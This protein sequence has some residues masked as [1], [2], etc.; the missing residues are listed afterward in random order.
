MTVSR[1]SFLAGAAV[2][3]VS[4]CGGRAGARSGAPS[5]TGPSGF[6]VTIPGR[7][8][9]AEIPGPPQRVVAVGRSRDGETSVAL[10]VIPVGMSRDTTGIAPGGVAPWVQPALAGR[11]TPTLLDTT[12]VPPLEAIASLAP[13]LVLATDYGPLAEQY[14]VLS[15]VAP[16]VSYTSSPRSDTWQDATTRIGAALGRREQAEAAI[17]DVEGRVAGARASHPQ[18]VG[19]TITFSV[20]TDRLYTSLP[21][22]SAVALLDQL[23]FRLAPQVTGLAAVGTTS[24]AALGDERLDLIDADVVVLSYPDDAT[25]R[26]IES[27]PVF[28]GLPAVAARRSVVLPYDVAVALAFPSLLSIPYALDRTVAALGQVLPG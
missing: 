7:E 16:T 17:R 19:R 21:N 6:P 4:A 8:G 12:P 26:R 9:T 5:A 3:G 14:T 27:R 20:A 28:A 11:P 23:G 10:G 18:F 25:R 13:D 15:Q 2:L 1:R 22:D 24:R